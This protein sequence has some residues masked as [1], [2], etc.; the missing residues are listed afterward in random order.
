MLLDRGRPADRAT[1]RSLLGEAEE[2]YARYGMPRHCEL[3]ERLL[4]ASAT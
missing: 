4:A 2:H 1:A 3:T